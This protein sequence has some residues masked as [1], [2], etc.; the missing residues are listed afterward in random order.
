MGY[1]LSSDDK[2]TAKVQVM[3]I[4]NAEGFKPTFE[5]DEISRM[6]QKI[7]FDLKQVFAA[8]CNIEIE[9]IRYKENTTIED[10]QNIMDTLA[11]EELMMKS[12]IADDIRD[13]KIS[14]KEAYRK[15]QVYVDQLLTKYGQ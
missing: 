12:N 13:K 7:E 11:T 15:H 14:E 8:R 4:E 9:K 3:L 10:L 1:N 6:K 5:C 2:K